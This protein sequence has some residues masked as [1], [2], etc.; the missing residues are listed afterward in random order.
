MKSFQA[1]CGTRRRVGVKDG[2]R[3]THLRIGET[4]LEDVPLIENDCGRLP[5]Q[6]A[7][8]EVP[9]LPSHDPS[10]AL[11]SNTQSSDSRAIRRAT[12]VL[13]WVRLVSG[14]KPAPRKAGSEAKS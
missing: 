4:F 10:A 1:R 12:Y 3:V 6:V 8:C 11:R 13:V 5:F 9:M 14:W 7:G 2:E